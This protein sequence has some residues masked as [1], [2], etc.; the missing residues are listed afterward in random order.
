MATKDLTILYYDDTDSTPSNHQWRKLVNRIEN[1]AFNTEAVIGLTNLPFRYGGGSPLLTCTINDRFGSQMEAALTLNNSGARHSKNFTGSTALGKNPLANGQINQYHGLLPEFTRIIIHESDSYMTLFVGRVYVVEEK[2]EWPYGNVMHLLCRD[3]LEEI[4]QGSLGDSEVIQM[5][6]GSD[7]VGNYPTS[8]SRQLDVIKDIIAKTSY[9]GATSAQEIVYTDHKIDKGATFLQGFNANDVSHHTDGKLRL[10][11]YGDTSPLRLIQNLANL[12]RWRS[13]TIDHL[14]FGFCLDATRTEPFYKN[15]GNGVSGTGI[16]PQDFL[17]FRKGHYPTPTPAD[18]G[19]KVVYASADSVAEN[20]G[21]SNDDRQRNMFNDFNFAGFADSSVTHIVLKHSNR[22]EQHDGVVANET[23]AANDGTW[24]KINLNDKTKD[25]YWGETDDRS[26]GVH[27]TD[28]QDERSTTFAM[29]YVDP[30]AGYS[31]IGTFSWKTGHTTFTGTDVD[32]QWKHVRSFRQV[33]SL[34]SGS[35]SPGA[36]PAV[37]RFKDG[38]SKTWLGNVQF[39]GVDDTGQNFLIISNPQEDKL[40]ALAEGV[41]LWESSSL[42]PLSG[43]KFKYYPAHKRRAKRT[44]FKNAKEYTVDSVNGLREALAHE[45]LGANN[46][47]VDRL[48]KGYFR[49]TDWPHMRWTSTAG[50]GTS[51]FAFP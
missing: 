29:L 31:T 7:G 34:H 42:T 35:Q 26:C 48:R 39:Q 11:N 4:A 38:S 32:D 12:E 23:T 37:N 16:L 46:K 50:S 5:V 27:I 14:G 18:Y 47:E 6:V 3:N 15:Y 49:I 19:L 40:L 24:D 33:S 51:G 44:I 17:Y 1:P 9:G 13:G 22:K 28:A 8:I 45:F 20:P 2:F 21:G 43:C 10:S 41:V 25:Y 36:S 30:L